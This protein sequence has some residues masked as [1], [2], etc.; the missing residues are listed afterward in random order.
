MEVSPI[1]PAASGDCMPAQPSLPQLKWFAT[2]QST[3]GSVCLDVSF[4]GPAPALYAR[5]LGPVVAVGN[6]KPV[7]KPGKVE[8]T[9][10]RVCFAGLVP[11]GY[12]VEIEVEFFDKSCIATVDASHRRLAGNA[13]LSRN[14]SSPSYVLQR[15]FKGCGHAHGL[16]YTERQRVCMDKAQTDLRL[17]SHVGLPILGSPAFV[18]VNGTRDVARVASNRCSPAELMQRGQWRPSPNGTARGDTFLWDAIG[19]KSPR[20]FG[21]AEAWRR[22]FRGQHIAFAGDS[23]TAEL[24]SIVFKTILFPGARYMDESNGCRTMKCEG[25]PWIRCQ[26]AG[27]TWSMLRVA[28]FELY[29]KCLPKLVASDGAQDPTLVFNAGV[30]Y[31]STGW[32]LAEI[33]AKVRG[34]LRHALASVN[35]SR[36][37]W[38]AQPAVHIRRA[39]WE[40]AAPP[41]PNGNR[42]YS[43]RG[44]RGFLNSVRI[45]QYNR[46]M[47]QLLSK[48]VEVWD[49]YRM[50]LALR[51]AQA[52]ALHFCNGPVVSVCRELSLALTNFLCNRGDAKQ[53]S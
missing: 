48:H 17:H 33:E 40:V 4:A 7:W 16:F 51:E 22:C 36:V 27:I 14:A 41:D 8:A 29:P 38:R 45:R 15:L 13:L 25:A 28:D 50:T 26:R 49:P 37:I 6:F 20:M 46:L 31:L 44:Q 39:Q 11:G 34:S 5:M 24:F 52:D 30:A 19:C 2:R 53:A 43:Y 32:P 42:Q 12:T 9:S 35:V 23:L 1:E 10:G 21:A 3:H 18:L 47:S